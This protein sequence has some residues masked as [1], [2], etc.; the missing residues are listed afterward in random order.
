MAV[1]GLPT[2]VTLEIVTPEASLV[3][4]EVDEVVLPGAKGYFG[5]WPGH[6]PLL[7][8]LTIGEMWYRKGAE[9]H[10]LA[11]ANGFA[12]VLPDRVT[13]LAEIAEREEDIDVDRAERAR[14][15]AE[16]RITARSTGVSDIDLERA[17]IAMMKSLI[18]LQVA[19]R[20]RTRA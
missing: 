6:A 12:E 14:Q 18:R 13:V 17:R 3:T 20:A 11:L 10:Y 15:R 7:A 4:T 16:E 5:V 1:E 8:L 9:K 2:K 19:S